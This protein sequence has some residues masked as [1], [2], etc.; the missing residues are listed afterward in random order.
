M[1]RLLVIC[2]ADPKAKDNAKKTPADYATAAGLGLPG[3]FVE[4]A[5]NEIFASSLVVSGSEH[6][7]ALQL[8]YEPTAAVATDL[9]VIYDWDGSSVA[10]FP[11]LRFTGFDTVELSLGA[12]I[13]A[14]PRHSE[15]G[16]RENLVFVQ[17]ELFF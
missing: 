16:D 15:Y 12:Q 17:A 1:A 2:G 11:Q 5:G 14:G 7:T 3:P 9:L 6:L 4:P 8:S 10:F 13:F